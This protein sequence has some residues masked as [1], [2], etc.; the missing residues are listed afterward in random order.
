[1]SPEATP[2]SRLRDS[3]RLRWV[4]LALNLLSRARIRSSHRIFALAVIIGV[5]A[6]LSSYAFKELVH[7]IHH[8]LTG[9]A[10][11]GYVDA[12]L[13]LGLWQRILIPTI[14]SVAAGLLLTAGKRIDN[15]KATDY[16]EAVALGNGDV[17][18][19]PSL[20]KS[21]AAACS[22]GSGVSIGRE[23]PLVQLAAVGASLLG[24][25]LK[26]PPAR[27]RLLVACG[28]A[29]GVAAAYNAPI[30]GAIFVAE[31]IIGSIAVESLGPLL[32]AS[33]ASTIT[34]RAIDPNLVSY[35]IDIPFDS[36]F[37]SV[38]LFAT[39]GTVCGFAAPLFIATLK[40]GKRLFAPIRLPLPF[41]LGFGGLLFG[42]IA[43]F[44][45]EVA[46]NGQSVIRGM[47]DGMFTWETIAMLA[48]LKVLAVTIVFGSG[49][50][51]GVFTPSLLVGAS[52]GYLWSVLLHHLGFGL[53]PPEVAALVGMG[54]FLAAATHAPFMAVFLLFE[55][56]L[57]PGILIPL[58]VATL[59][60][61]S[62]ARGLGGASLY[63]ESLQSG[64]RSVFD[65]DIATLTV[66]EIVRPQA[67]QTYPSSS[68][69]E[70]AT[71]FLRASEGMLPVTDQDG[72]FLGSILLQDVRP[73]L[74]ERALADSIIARDILRDDI[75]TLDATFD[76]PHAL[77]TF[78]ETKHS[79]LPVTDSKTG[80]LLGMLEKNDLYLVVSEITRRAGVHS[81]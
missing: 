70:V 27:L 58:T 60:S 74:K 55:M 7:G 9:T 50:V 67:S 43:A 17:P 42:L 19:R 72:H 8:L 77:R 69:G 1:M 44:H 20:L 40:T 56:C 38:V 26:E 13:H 46:G 66:S 47:L 68:F 3:K 54:C 48:L 28:A 79:A 36:G 29:G 57:H 21:I 39:L 41:K 24:R 5:T 15:R 2:A 78:S 45:P 34:I 31:I 11:K 61:Y 63:L 53:I 80:T 18:A 10:S 14:G 52:I 81:T 62:I 22:I 65:K 49:T 73:Y 25:L 32:A 51:G 33:V 6:A 12:F 30:G 4:Y 37:A 76:L 16:M 23:G 64:P 71:R 35:A 59:L 75:P